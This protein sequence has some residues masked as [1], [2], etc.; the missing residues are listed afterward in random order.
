[1]LLERLFS[2]ADKVVAARSNIKPRNV[3]MILSLTKNAGAY[4]GFED[5]GGLQTSARGE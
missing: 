4:L 1:M 5:R 2:K 3:D